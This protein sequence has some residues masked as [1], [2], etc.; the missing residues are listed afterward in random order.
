[1]ERLLEAYFSRFHA[2]CPILDR[3]SLLAAVRNNAVSITLLKCVV[4][5]ASIHCDAEILHVMGY[6]T[7]LDAEDDLFGRACAS[8]DAD[9]EADRTTIVLSSYLLHYWFGKPTSY[10]DSLW[11]LANS[12]RSAQCMGYHRSTKHSKM[13]PDDKTRFKLIWWC[14]YVRD[15]QVS[16]STGTPMVINEL[17]YDVEDLTMDD[18]ARESPETARYVVAQAMLNKTASNLYFLHCAPTR[19]ASSPEGWKTAREQIQAALE[20]WYADAMGAHDHRSSHHHLTLTLK[21]CYQ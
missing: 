13:S 14:L 2:F 1:M 20:S 17:D 19:L 5:V 21:V 8:F 7:R 6:A 12:I 9:R 16:F 4:F 11:W 10:R 15:R 3:T 18:L